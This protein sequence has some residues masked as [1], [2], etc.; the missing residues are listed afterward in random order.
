MLCITY[1]ILLIE[2]II[3]PFHMLYNVLWKLDIICMLLKDVTLYCLLQIIIL[4]P[5][6]ILNIALCQDG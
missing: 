5:I 1:C 2:I 4:N 3:L 6:C